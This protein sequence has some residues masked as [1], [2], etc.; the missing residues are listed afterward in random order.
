VLAEATDSADFCRFICPEGSFL[1]VPAVNAGRDCLLRE[2]AVE[3]TEELPRDDTWSDLLDDLL[4]GGKLR[5]RGR[6]VEAKWSL[7]ARL[8]RVRG[9]PPGGQLASLLLAQELSE[10]SLAPLF[11]SGTFSL[12]GTLRWRM[13]G[14]HAKQSLEAT[15]HLALEMSKT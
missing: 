13:Q 3:E 1:G 12:A 11:D 14:V 6:A 10:S 5:R 9:V 7:E 15:Q 4:L 8:L 2:L